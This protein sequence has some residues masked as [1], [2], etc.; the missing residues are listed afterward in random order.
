M[1]KAFSSTQKVVNK[2]IQN[3]SAKQYGHLW[4]KQTLSKN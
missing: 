4:Q 3:E 2:L 1:F